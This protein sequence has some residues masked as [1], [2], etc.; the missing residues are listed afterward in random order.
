VTREKVFF[1]DAPVEYLGPF[2]FI[3]AIVGPQEQQITAFN[4]YL[5]D[6]YHFNAQ[7][8]SKK[9]INLIIL[10]VSITEEKLCE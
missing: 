4:K 10:G 2:K 7:M 1:E 6:N 5:Q 8:N 3:L 9:D